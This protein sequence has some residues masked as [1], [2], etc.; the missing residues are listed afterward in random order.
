MLGHWG[1]FIPEIMKSIVYISLHIKSL[2][3]AV[4]ELATSATA[5]ARAR[6]SAYSS[7][8]TDALI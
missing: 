2:N 7:T 6:A 4:S 5:T 1:A 3:E 8:L